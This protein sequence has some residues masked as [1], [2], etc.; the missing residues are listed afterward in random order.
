MGLP[1]QPLFYASFLFSLGFFC[2]HRWLNL[3]DHYKKTRINQEAKRTQILLIIPLPRNSPCWCSRFSFQFCF[4]LFFQCAVY[5]HDLL[6]RSL[7]GCTWTFCR[8]AIS[9]FVFF[10]REIPTPIDSCISSFSIIM[11]QDQ[12]RAVFFPPQVD[13]KEDYKE[14]SSLKSSVFCFATKSLAWQCLHNISITN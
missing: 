2:F 7:F 10:S 4:A 14:I 5:L 11:N 13:S 6:L 1:P 3:H 12:Y 8:K 9:F